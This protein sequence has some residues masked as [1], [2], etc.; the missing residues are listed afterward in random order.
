MD[1][2]RMFDIVYNLTNGGPGTATETLASTVYKMTF[3]YMNVG[4]GSAMAFVFMLIIVIC[5]WL[6]MKLGRSE[7]H[8]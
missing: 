5:S 1:A 8:A 3:R 2:I 7:K 6:L 4:E